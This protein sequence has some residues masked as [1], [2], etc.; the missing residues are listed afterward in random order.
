MTNLRMCA[1]HST[2]RSFGGGTIDGDDF[3][4]THKKEWEPLC[5][6][7]Y[8]ENGSEVSETPWRGDE[9]DGSEVDDSPW[10]G[11]DQEESEDSSTLVEYSIGILYMPMLLGIAEAL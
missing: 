3:C 6:P 9:Q 2:R 8:L 4:T 10:H 5:C 1:K 11:D 7:E